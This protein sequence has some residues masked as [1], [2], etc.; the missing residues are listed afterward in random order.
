MYL[1]NKLRNYNKN[2]VFHKVKEKK[3]LSSIIKLSKIMNN[4]RRK[5]KQFFE[6]SKSQSIN[7][8]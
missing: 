7:K 8:N 3:L 1:E 5:V 2:I 6:K 4:M